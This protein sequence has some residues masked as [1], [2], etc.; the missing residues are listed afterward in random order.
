VYVLYM[1][2]RMVAGSVTGVLYNEGDYL[3]VADKN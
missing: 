2:Y 1:I 3:K